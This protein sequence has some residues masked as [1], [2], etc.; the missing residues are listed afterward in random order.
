MDI[1]LGTGNNH[2]LDVKVEISIQVF[3]CSAYS[4]FAT[5]FPPLED[6]MHLSNLARRA[7]IF[8]VSAT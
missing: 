8:E 6:G 7:H 5:Q 3:S 1:C 4:L 2:K